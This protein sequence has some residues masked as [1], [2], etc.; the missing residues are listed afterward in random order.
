MIKVENI[1]K[2]KTDEPC[3]ELI[4]Y[5]EFPLTYLG[6]GERM[7]ITMSNY[8]KSKG[9]KTTL[10]VNSNKITNSRISLQEINSRISADIVYLKFSR[11]GLVKFIFQDLPG[12][13]FV[14]NTNASIQMLLLRRIPSKFYLNTISNLDKKFIFCLHGIALENYK[15]LPLKIFIYQ[16]LV[17]RQLKLIAKTKARNIYVQTLIPKVRDYLLKCG[18]DENQVVTIENAIMPNFKKIE[19]NYE[20]FRVIFISRMEDLVK[21]ITMLKKVVKY[22]GEVM[23]KIKFNIIGIGPDLYILKELNGNTN[24]LGNV[25]DIE[26]QKYLKESNLGIITSNL[27]PYSLVAL[28]FLFAGLPV[29]TTPASGPSNILEK[30]NIFG[31]ISSFN[32]KKFAKDL[33]SYYEK[34]KC[35]EEEYFVMRKII[36]EEAKRIFSIDEMYSKYELLVNSLNN[37]NV[38]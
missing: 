13:D 4:L 31:K 38:V 12:L 37:K 30:S 32:F 6:G 34:W 8:F 21:G 33:I 18:M 25:S 24:L 22:V 5:S 29:V 23:P 28:E 15:I 26:K 14:K 35:D 11:Y 19:N 3:E 2:P 9:F 16:I 17:R 10:C 20:E 7:L 1:K 36:A 27:E